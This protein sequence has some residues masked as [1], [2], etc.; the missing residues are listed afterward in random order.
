MLHA[1]SLKNNVCCWKSYCSITLHGTVTIIHLRASVFSVNV[2]V[3]AVPVGQD[4]SGDPLVG[5]APSLWWNSRYSGNVAQV[6]LQPLATVVIARAPGANGVHPARPGR[7]V[8]V[9]IRRRTQEAVTDS[10]VLCSQWNRASSCERANECNLS[11][12]GNSR[13]NWSRDND[14]ISCGDINSFFYSFTVEAY[15]NSTYYRS[16]KMWLSSESQQMG[17]SS[18]SSPHCES[19]SYCGVRVLK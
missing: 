8:V 4:I 15:P 5:I 7:Q 10:L 18:G 2:E 11:T 1:R 19:E 12:Q 3:S 9:V 17:S 13:S 6:Q 16:S 14:D